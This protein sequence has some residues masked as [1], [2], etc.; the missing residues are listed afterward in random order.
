M[1]KQRV[2]VLVIG[3]GRHQQKIKAA[4][5][6][7]LDGEFSDAAKWSFPDSTTHIDFSGPARDL[8]LQVLSMSIDNDQLALRSE[9]IG[10]FWRRNLSAGGVSEEDLRGYVVGYAIDPLESAIQ[11]AVRMLNDGFVDPE[12]ASSLAGMK[13]QRHLERLLELQIKKLA[14]EGEA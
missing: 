11:S 6:K 2:E 9:V 1:S 4:I 7:A 14:S 13:L 5:Y 8:S 12:N 10:D 3:A